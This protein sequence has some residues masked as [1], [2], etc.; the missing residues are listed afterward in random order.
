MYDEVGLKGFVQILFEREGEMNA[1]LEE[2][3]EDEQHLFCF[4]RTDPIVTM[5]LDCRISLSHKTVF[6]TC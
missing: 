5:R 3:R 6:A 4:D 1:T 2:E